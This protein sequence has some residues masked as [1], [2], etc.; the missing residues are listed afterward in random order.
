MHDGWMYQGR[1]YHMWFGHGTKPVD[2]SSAA[3]GKPDL[4]S[5]DERIHNLGHTLVAGLP[6]SKR[7]HATARLGA[8]DHARLDRVMEGVVRALP[9]GP[10]VTA[11]RVLGMHPDGR[12]VEAF[13]DAGRILAS[14]QTHADLRA[15]TDKVAASAQEM[16]LDNFKP[17]L[18]RADDHLTGT[19]GVLALLRDLPKPP[20]PAT[21]PPVIRP[22]ARP[23]LPPPGQ[24][25]PQVRS[26]LRK[27]GLAGLAL[28]A[29]EALIGA[30][31]EAEI[32]AAIERFKLDPTKAGDVAAAL[33]YVWASYNRALLIVTPPGNGQ[34]GASVPE[35]AQ[36]TVAEHVMR[37]AQNDP[38]LLD[39]AMAGDAGA[40]GTIRSIVRTVA[41]GLEIITRNKEE[42][43]LVDKMTAEGKSSAEIQ[44]ALDEFRKRVGVPS[45]LD[46]PNNPDDL[47]KRGW[48][49]TTHPDATGTGHREFENPDTGEKISFDKGRPGQPGF[50]GRDHYHRLNPN[51]SSKRESNL[52]VH[53]NPVPR[54]SKRS[55]II[56]GESS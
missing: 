32:R 14:A 40:L 28:T 35:S 56:S 6:A 7:Y 54:G 26:V 11:L 29:L 3:D 4:G 21:V 2:G 8:D 48:I 16:G 34:V 30:H 10:R 12:G 44:A 36:D 31:R 55:H 9:L 19:G 42:R 15:A 49:E 46:L 45:R 5:I 24:L 41:S 38:T 17:F 22:P 52:D 53:G 47:L 37:A 27:A 25:A 13:V 43:E 39:R 51:P 20:S 50:E 33:A 18:R 1:Q 23:V